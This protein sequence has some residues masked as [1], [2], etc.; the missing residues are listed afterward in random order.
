MPFA[1]RILT[2]DGVSYEGSND[3]EEPGTGE[4]ILALM[5]RLNL[6]NLLLVVTQWDTGCRGRLGT[7]LYH[8][9]IDR[10]KELLEDL[11]TTSNENPDENTPPPPALEDAGSPAPAVSAAPLNPRCFSF[12]ALP[13]AVPARSGDRGK[14]GPNHFMSDLV[15]PAMDQRRQ[16]GMGLFDQSSSWGPG[17]EEVWEI[18]E[19]ALGDIS[20]QDFLA[21]RA[22]ARPVPAVVRVTFAVC[23]LKGAV[24][25]TAPLSW[26]TCRE[27]LSSPTLRLELVLLNPKQ[28]SSSRARRAASLL[29]ETPGLAKVRRIHMALGNLM[30]WGLRMLE[31]HGIAVQSATR[32][33]TFNVS[34]QSQPPIRP[35]K[36]THPAMSYVGPGGPRHGR[37]LNATIGRRRQPETQA[38][39]G[40][41]AS[42]VERINQ[43]AGSPHHSDT[44]FA[45]QP[46]PEVEPQ[47]DIANAAKVVEGALLVEDAT[48]EE[49]SLAI[50]QLGEERSQIIQKLAGAQHAAPGSPTVAPAVPP[51]KT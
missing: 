47:V 48:N 15:D 2:P 4:K 38:C 31:W 24:S 12:E 49:L 44:E 42:S 27:M 26:A 19:N 37:G 8:C 5:Q 22:M 34:Q 43:E 50:M 18:N 9:I 36:V 7:S 41:L 1:Y 28:I 3:D 33:T 25:A 29:S 23:L 11:K 20:K 16:G 13:Q 17:T 14:Y 21:L 45:H 32:S 39:L 30:E 10:C 6:D 40:A 51:P 46:D 35:L